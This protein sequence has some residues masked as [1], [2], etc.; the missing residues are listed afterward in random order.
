MH[1][2]YPWSHR[3]MCAR[4]IPLP[5]VKHISPLLFLGSLALTPAP[6]L[7]AFRKIFMAQA[8]GLISE[9]LDFSRVNLLRFHLSYILPTFL[10]RRIHRASSFIHNFLPFLCILGFTSATL[11]LQ[12]DFGLTVTLTLTG[13][14]MLFIADF[15]TRNLL[16]TLLALIPIAWH[17]YFH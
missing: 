15:Q 6:Y 1:R 17:S 12:P 16:Y 13:C 7:P 9:V 8:D 5:L 11:L 4:F 14:A 10:S 3:P 2:P